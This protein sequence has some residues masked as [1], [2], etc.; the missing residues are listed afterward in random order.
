MYSRKCNRFTGGFSRSYKWLL[1]YNAAD[2]SNVL[3]S[4]DS[5]CAYSIKLGMVICSNE[6]VKVEKLHKRRICEKIIIITVRK[7]M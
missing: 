2:Y 4:Y 6:T 5:N 7:I 1:K 3:G